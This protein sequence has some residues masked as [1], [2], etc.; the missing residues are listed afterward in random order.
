M[1]KNY[2]KHKITNIINVSEIVTLHYFEFETDFVFKEERHD[3]WELVYVD[4]GSWEINADNEKQI[5]SQGECFF[6]KPGEVHLHR[7]TGKTPPNIFL[8]SFVCNS[9]SMDF[10]KSKK[11][12]IPVNL[13]FFI[14]NIIEESIKTFNLPFNEPELKEL[15]LL[16]D[17]VLGGQQMIKTYLEQFLILLM[18]YQESV[19]SKNIFPSVELKGANLAVRMKEI[20]DNSVYKHITVEEFCRDMKYSKAYLSKIFLANCGC[21]I[22]TYINNVKIKEAK[23]LIRENTYNFS[24]ISDMLCFSNPLYFSRVFRRITS[25][26]PSEYKNSVKFN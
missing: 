9:K 13:R 26:S 2:K 12:H 16:S 18:R 11:M 1:R 10:F 15:S 5:L 7:A 17:S 20:L 4:R 25:M 19:P 24:Q 6:H 8:I 14:S 21:T 23:K 22:N 3:F